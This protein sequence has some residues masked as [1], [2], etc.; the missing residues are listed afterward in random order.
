VSDKNFYIST[1][2]SYPNGKPHIG[3]AYEVM[4]T[5]A[6]AR[7]HR[8]SGENVYFSTGT[9]DHGQKMFQTAR[10][11]GKTAQ[12]LADELTPA[13][14]DMAEMLNCS[15]DD[16]IRTSEPRH[17]AAVQEIWRKIAAKGDIY[18]DNYAGWYSVRD[19]AFYTE[20]ELSDGPDGEKLSPQGTPVEWLEEDSYFFK[21]SAYQDAL[22]AY[23]EAHPEFIQP[24]SRR[25]EVV[26]FVKGGLKDLS[27]S[28]T[29]FDW[30][31]PVPDDPAHV[32]YVWM[33]ALTNY[34]SVLQY[35]E[36]EG[37]YAEFW[38]AALHVIGKDITRF[39]AVYWPAFLM[40]A[41]LPLPQQ[42]FAH[43]FLTVKGE[44]M[45]KSL[46]NVL[47][48][49]TL[50]EHYGVD[51]LRYFFL[52]EVPFGRDG[53]FSDEAIVNRVNADLA[54]D[55]GNLAQRSLSMIGKNCDATLPTPQALSPEDE[56]V[57]A[58]F[59]GLK[60]KTDAAMQGH[61]LHNYLGAVMDG[62]SEANRYFAAQE[63]WALKKTDPARMG[64]VLYVTA[65]LV[66]QAAILLQPVIPDGAARLLDYLAVS[67]DARDFAHLGAA[68]RLAPGG[69][70]PTPEG[71][72][73]RLAMAA[74]DA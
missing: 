41:D 7:Y 34:L 71:V 38:P 50:A 52:R 61:E 23:Y 14:R 70:L 16:F 8:L 3:H 11:Q 56:A 46:G 12:A 40:A 59:D 43:G 19:E 22:L 1:A 2:I 20:S 48:P 33:D 32:I 64:T 36:T 10:D 4:A 5:D 55:I 17:H 29:A 66:R 13:F 9:D 54:N 26:S 18:R 74:T 21:L 68:H 28:R 35:P 62:V 49:F 15:H 31:V 42:V 65:E 37:R 45:S 63:P 72:F 6:I 24:E 73:P 27:I 51:A 47:D 30:G 53:S 60:A 25:N 67:A 57:L 44:K 39:H 58:L 69:R